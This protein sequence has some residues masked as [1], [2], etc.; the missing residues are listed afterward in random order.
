MSVTFNLLSL[1]RQLIR[2]AF[3][4]V[5]RDI[6]DILFAEQFFAFKLH[7]IFTCRRPIDTKLDKVVTY[8]KM[9]SPLKSRDPL[10]T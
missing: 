6:C 10:I 4:N 3:S 9:P 1:V 7:Y 8:Y 2:L 5:L